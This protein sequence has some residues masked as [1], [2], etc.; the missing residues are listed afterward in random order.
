[1]STLM[2]LQCR[3]NNPNDSN[4]QFPC[5]GQQ[6]PALAEAQ[7]PR[8]ADN[9]YERTLTEQLTRPTT[10]E[11]LLEVLQLSKYLDVFKE[12]NVDLAKLLTMN[13]DDLKD[14]GIK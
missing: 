4:P 12:H 5:A 7:G 1:M 8:G 14:I 9:D 2:K 13:G 3:L 11:E 6:H 10:I